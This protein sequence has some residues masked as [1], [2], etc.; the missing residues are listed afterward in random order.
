MP[1]Q[2]EAIEQLGQSDEEERKQ[3]ARIPLIIEQDVEMIEGIGVEQVGLVEE[4][5]GV[6]A[7]LAELLD[8]RADRVEDRCGGGRGAE[9]P[10]EA[11]LAVEVALA[12][13]GVMA[14]GESVFGL[15]Q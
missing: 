4:E 10:G 15:G 7:L 6:K 5:D 12:E 14:V 8:V 13:R 3:R 2:R 9:P 11:E 1:A